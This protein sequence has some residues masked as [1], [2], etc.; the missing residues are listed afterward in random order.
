MPLFL[1][2]KMMKTYYT[3]L[4]V[5]L[6]SGIGFSQQLPVPFNYLYQP[7][8]Y[9]PSLMGALDGS[10]VFAGYRSQWSDFG[11]FAPTTQYAVFNSN[12][13]RTNETPLLSRIGFGV[14]LLN[15][16][17][18]MINRTNIGLS[19]SYFLVDN[20]SLTLSAGFTVG[21]WTQQIDLLS[22]TFEQGGDNVLWLSESNQSKLDISFGAN[23][24][25]ALSDNLVLNIGLTV[26]QLTSKA[27]DYSLDSINYMFNPNAHL[28]T[29]FGFTYKT[30]GNLEISPV[31]LYRGL[32]GGENR[33]MLGGSIE[34]GIRVGYPISD[35]LK[36][37][38]GA[39]A[40]TGSSVGDETSNGGTHALVRMDYNNLAFQFI[41][42]SNSN[43]GNS[44]EVGVGFTFG[45]GSKSCQ[46]MESL[47]RIEG[48]AIQ[49]VKESD[50]AKITLRQA[51]D[52]A[53]STLDQLKGNFVCTS[54]DELRN[55]I[56]QVRDYQLII[57]ENKQQVSLR[58]QQLAGLKEEA[59][60]ANCEKDYKKINDITIGDFSGNLELFNTEVE[61]I[62]QQINDKPIWANPKA[63]SARV[64]GW[65]NRVKG[66]TSAVENCKSMTFTYADEDDGEYIVTSMRNYNGYIKSVIDV[67][68]ETQRATPS[69]TITNISITFDIN[70]SNSQL[71]K[72][73][74]IQYG[75]ELED[76]DKSYNYQNLK[77]LRLNDGDDIN[78][79]QLNA[80]K[81]I[82]L[83]SE[84]AKQIGIDESKISITLNAGKTVEFSRNI[85]IKVIHQE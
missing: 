51:Y 7:D 46:D 8:L 50:E 54:D 53:Q 5:L 74:D 1:T 81:A 2:I 71:R 25:A 64:G 9:N 16:R 80:L 21:S 60:A 49:L 66:I 26:L 42:E 48:K 55:K 14:S 72:I 19:G 67:L 58:Q 68:K 52:D 47:N 56:K 28:L 36:F 40:R 33:Q 39:G 31:I 41:G 63:L 4:F 10:K 34:A 18:G 78:F 75:S 62:E 73:A 59:K 13:L 20:E 30:G 23:A 35:E 83:R 24:D 65:S 15:D 37:S 61:S 17:F 12:M 45:S 84:I 82:S 27:F 43:L 32:V 38:L 29:S 11:D 22:A 79:E 85:E 70:R 3:L 76:N 77:T 57:N 6:F 44:F 69:R